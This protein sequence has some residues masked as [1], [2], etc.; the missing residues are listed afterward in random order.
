MRTQLEPVP[1]E[2][3]GPCGEIVRVDAIVVEEDEAGHLRRKTRQVEVKSRVE[4]EAFPAKT[5]HT[6]KLATDQR[7]GGG[8]GP[9]FSNAHLYRRS[10]LMMSFTSAETAGATS[11]EKLRR[12]K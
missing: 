12:K 6:W 7:G 3:S 9:G 5:E 8:V 11:G 1:H 10:G 4:H 2:R